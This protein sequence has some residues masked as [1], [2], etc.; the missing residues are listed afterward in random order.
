MKPERRLPSAFEEPL[1]QFCLG[2]TFREEAARLGPLERSSGV[3][4]DAI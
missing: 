3:R 1:V 2:N 4:L